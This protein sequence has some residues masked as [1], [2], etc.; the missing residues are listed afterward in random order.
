MA[1]RPIVLRLYLLDDRRVDLDRVSPLIERLARRRDV[2][3]TIPEW[4]I[5]YDTGDPSEAM[6]T[7]AADLDGIDPRW[8]EIFDFSAVRRDRLRPTGLRQAP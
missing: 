3:G 8:V 6:G 4:R 7:C 5:V 2:S 1:S